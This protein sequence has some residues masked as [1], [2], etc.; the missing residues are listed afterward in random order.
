MPFFWPMR[1]SSWNQISTGLP[2]GRSARW[3]LSVR[4]K[5]FIS[6]DDLAVLARVTRAG[7]D[8][9]EPEFLQRRADIT[10]LIGDAEA[11]FDEFL[12][13]DAPPAHDAFDSPIRAGLH[14]PRQLHLLLRRQAR[15]R[16]AVPGILE[17]VRASLVE[18]VT[19]VPQRLPVHAADPGGF[20]TAHPV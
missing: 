20:L 17:T 9:R 6:L 1:A 15:L 13:V 7:A 3:A 11:F 18:A 4:A 19:P 2:L 16:P 10:L 8:V 5:F 14:D 12:K